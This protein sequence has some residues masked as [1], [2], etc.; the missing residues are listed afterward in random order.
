MPEVRMPTVVTPDRAA[1]RAAGPAR[2]A[3]LGRTP[4]PQ[5]PWWATVAAAAASMGQRRRSRSRRLGPAQR[6]G[7]LALAI[8]AL[9]A[10]PAALALSRVA[11]DRRVAREVH[12]L[13]AAAKGRSRLVT[14]ADLVGLPE[15]VQRWLRWSNVV[16]TAGPV[17]VRLRQEGQFRMGQDRGWMPFQA[18]AYYTTDP[19]G[20]V[21][22]VSLGM[23]P[24]VTVSGRD[25]YADGQ[26]SI[27]MRLLALI[28]VANDHSSGLNQGAMLRFL[29]ETMWFPAGVLSPSITWAARDATSAVAWMRYGGVSASATFVFDDQGR[30]AN[31]TAERF[32]NARKAML[33]W[34]TPISAYGQFAG[35]RVP[36]AGTGVWHYEQGGFPYIRLRVT[37]LEYNRPQPY[38]RRG[39]RRRRPSGRER[40]IA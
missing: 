29:N 9:L 7:K 31:M 11:L 18:Q 13:F 32:D 1:A 39:R 14:E 22:N 23:A 24:L 12:G 38:R 10:V 33:A 15:P 21:W 8:P 28:P 2:R 20:Y 3:A 27:L 37:D 16:G 17:T 34:S 4:G 40:I 5:G 35:V 6:P 30:L 36:V 26:A 19:P 25:R